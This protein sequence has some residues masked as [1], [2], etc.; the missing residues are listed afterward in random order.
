MATRPHGARGFVAARPSDQGWIALEK[1]TALLWRELVCWPAGIRRAMLRG[2]APAS[3]SHCRICQRQRP[4]PP[5][6]QVILTDRECRARERANLIKALQRA[7]GRIYGQG[8]AA[9][10]RGGNA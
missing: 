5:T 3:T 4:Q 6:C 8:G 10:L 9:E 2:C 1:E 7:D